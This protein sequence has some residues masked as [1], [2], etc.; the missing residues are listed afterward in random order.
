M[1]KKLIELEDY[2]ITDTGETVVTRDFLV[3]K[4]LSGEP[5]TG[6]LAEF[7]EDI[8]H[9]NY[10][11]PDA[12]IQFW[13]EGDLEGPSEETYQW[14]IPQEYQDIDV[15]SYVLEKFVEMGLEG[16]DYVNRIE[17]ELVEMEKRGY[18]PFIRCIIYVLDTFRKNAVVWGV[19]R[20][21]ACAS[22]LFY[23]IGATKVDPIEY[24]IPIEEFLK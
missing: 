17:Y 20:G 14:I 11:T 6:Y 2:S 10:R 5:I 13:E 7:H 4:A 21:S 3:K 18:F 23:V 8:K 22:L 9:Y 19:G 16:E 12:P 15:M 1:S 24:E